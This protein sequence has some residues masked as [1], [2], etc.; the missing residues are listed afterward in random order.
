MAYEP[1]SLTLPISPT[2][3]TGAKFFRETAIATTASFVKV[4][5]GGGKQS[6]DITETGGA[7]SLEYSFDGTNTAGVLAAGATVSLNT[8]S[9]GVWL[10]NGSGIAE[11]T[12]VARSSTTTPSNMAT[13]TTSTLHL[14]A[15]AT[16]GD[17][18][19]DGY[20]LA[21][22]KLTLQAV[23]DLVPDIVKHLVYVHLAGTFVLT[24]NVYVIRT[25][26]PGGIIL[27][28]GDETLRTAVDD[29]AGSNYTS[30]ASGTFLLT[31]AAAAWTVDEHTGYMVEVLTGPA[32][33]QVRTVH[34]NTAQDLVPTKPFSVDPTIGATYRIIRPT[35]EISATA[36][37]YV[38]ICFGGNTPTAS[39][40]SERTR[41]NWLTLSGDKLGVSVEAVHFVMANVVATGTRQNL[42]F[43]STGANVLLAPSTIDYGN[44]PYGSLVD[45]GVGAVATPVA[46]FSKYGAVVGMQGSA[47]KKVIL[48]NTSVQMAGNRIG[49]A[50][51]NY[52][53][54]L[55]LSAAVPD[56]SAFYA[57]N[58]FGSLGSPV[59][60]LVLNRSNLIVQ[61]ATVA[62]ASG[63]G[64]VVKD[65]S[66]LKLTGVVDGANTVGG[67]HVYGG[68]KLEIKNSTPPTITNGTDDLE[69]SVDGS[70]EATDFATVAAGTNLI[71]STVTLAEI[72][73]V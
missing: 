46:I 60:G 25:C 45:A 14:Y 10:K 47:F 26:L 69:I 71:E 13:V 22:P 54:G 57:P 40:A 52:C 4:D 53:V 31:H 7:E 51:L 39:S 6:V 61:K 16:T 29:N 24:D 73:G 34:S 35:T 65:N 33:G 19:N 9:N 32:A 67:I 5:F 2:P 58:D 1:T 27:L 59:N 63:F 43:A 56:W 20:S 70:T 37:S 49:T 11:A 50:E 44:K 72:V 21:A 62:G 17:D 41:M 68:S 66:T 36:A 48:D 28:D 15:N 55:S 3:V 23:F 42:I 18:S 30:T 38:S 12:V 8:F 64:I